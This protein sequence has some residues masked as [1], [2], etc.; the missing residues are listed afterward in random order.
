RRRPY[1]VVL[2][3]EIE[4]AHPGVFNV[5]LQ[6]FEEGRLTDGQGRTVDFRNTIVIMTSN[7]GAREIAKTAPIGFSTSSDGGGLSDKEI[8]SHVMSEVR[9]TFRPEFLN[10]LD[11]IIVFKA[12]T[13]DELKQIVD[14]MVADLRDR[15]IAQNMTINL[16]DAA[17][18]YIV[19]Q[20]TDSTYGA[21]PLRRAI[22]RLVEDPVSEGILEG[23]WASGSVIDVDY[24]GEELV[25]KAGVGEIPAPRKR[26]TM[27]EKRTLLLPPRTPRGTVKEGA[28][29][30]SLSE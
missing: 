3:D 26:T 30:E 28:G 23:K 10:R 2:F 6:I 20:G 25:F 21:R 12:L 11:D 17:R 18:G 9:K 22:Q 24:D 15:L 16:T 1:S 8:E 7:V 13:N 4:K 27:A 19:E 14:L 5:L 29:D